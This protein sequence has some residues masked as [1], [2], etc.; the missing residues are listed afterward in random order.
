MLLSTMILAAFLSDHG[1]LEEGRCGACKR[2]GTTSTVMMDG[3]GACTLLHCGSGYFD[4]KG[5]FHPPT[6]CNT[7]TYGGR[8]SRGHSV[9]QVFKQ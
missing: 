4:E 8:C 5:V 2:W 3:F 1:A 9:S 6:P 7:C